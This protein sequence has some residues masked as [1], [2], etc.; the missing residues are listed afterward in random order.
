MP[1]TLLP[2]IPS[3]LHKVQSILQN[4]HGVRE[5]N[6]LRY[7]PPPRAACQSGT[8]FRSSWHTLQ[9]ALARGPQHF[10]MARRQASIHPSIDSCI[11]HEPTKTFCEGKCKPQHTKHL[12]KSKSSSLLG[13]FHAAAPYWKPPK[14]RCTSFRGE[15]CL[16]RLRAWIDLNSLDKFNL[17]RPNSALAHS[18][19][20]NIPQFFERCC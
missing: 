1:S 17:Q 12:C 3:S 16:Y 13:N 11:I 7:P 8:A 19:T 18:E 14:S 5:R 20:Q 6:S 4:K 9:D 2:L 10:A 15:S